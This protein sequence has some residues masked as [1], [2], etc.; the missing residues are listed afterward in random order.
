MSAA[1]AP[2]S[3]LDA[4]R[5]LEREVG[6]LL[7]RTRRALGERAR[8]VHPD[9]TT[10]GYLVLAQIEADG[11]VRGS[12]LSDVLHLDKGAV[13]RAVQHLLE[14]DLVDRTRDPGDGRA[15]LL[16][17]S[18]EGGRRAR[19]VDE[20]RR[21]MLRRRLSDWSC[22]DLHDVA[23]SLHRYNAAVETAGS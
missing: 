10:A 18:A 8:L 11:P 12:D 14:L 5:D 1:W 7:R 19:A 17:V 16:S 13:S 23:E 22:D 6:V 20:A 15:T 2:G 21:D 9:L 4:L 3:S